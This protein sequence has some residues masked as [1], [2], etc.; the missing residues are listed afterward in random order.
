MYY[1]DDLSYIEQ[2]EYVQENLDNEQLE[3]L[4]IDEIVFGD[5][6]KYGYFFFND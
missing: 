1:F 6:Y 5:I 3:S 2:R 4:L